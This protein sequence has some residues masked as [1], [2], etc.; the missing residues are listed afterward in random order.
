MLWFNLFSI[1][2]CY[3][4]SFLRLMSCLGGGGSYLGLI[5]S[6]QEILFMIDPCC[7][8]SYLELISCPCDSLFRTELCCVSY[9][10]FISCPDGILFRIDSCCFVSY[11]ELILSSGV[12]YLGFK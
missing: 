10:G 9:L 7:S 8:V 12:S 4:V 5:L 6:P 3:S 11:L 2:S 1:Y